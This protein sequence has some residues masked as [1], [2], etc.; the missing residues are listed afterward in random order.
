MWRSGSVKP[1]SV[2]PQPPAPRSGFRGPYRLLLSMAVLA[3][4]VVF[5]FP[6]IFKPGVELPAELQFASP[7]SLAVQISN[8]N[9]TPLTDVEYSCEVSKLTLANG[10]AI[11]DAKILTRGTI[12]KIPG[13][14]TITAHCEAAHTVAGPVNAAEYNLTLTYRTYPWPQQRTSVYHIAAQIS[15]G[16]RFTG[17]KLN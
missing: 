8:Q 16:G 15:G 5:V 13:R 4:T 11:G 1:E 3:V 12:R 6:V 17:W 10:S 14:H 7:F 9:L 2:S